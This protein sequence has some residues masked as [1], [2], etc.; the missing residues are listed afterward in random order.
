MTNSATEYD[1]Y[2]KVDVQTASQGK[3]IV[4]LFNG[5]IQR[6]EERLHLRGAGDRCSRRCAS[7]EVANGPSSP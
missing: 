5:A 6:A 4:M 3:L 7:G 1:A 2:K